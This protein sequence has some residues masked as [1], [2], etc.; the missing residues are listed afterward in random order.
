MAKKIERQAQDLGVKEEWFADLVLSIV[1]G[2]REPSPAHPESTPSVHRGG[3]IETAR[4]DAA[5][6]NAANFGTDPS[7]Y[8]Q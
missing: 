6:R 8:G 1:K 4:Q 5:V 2:Q 7:W 3:S